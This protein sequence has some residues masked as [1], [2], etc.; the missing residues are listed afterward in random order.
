[1]RNAIMTPFGERSLFSQN[2]WTWNSWKMF[3][4]QVVYFDLLAQAACCA[5]DKAMAIQTWQL[6][7]GQDFFPAQ[8]SE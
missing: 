1:M 5:P 3:H 7:L 4:E 6:L 8:V 2:E